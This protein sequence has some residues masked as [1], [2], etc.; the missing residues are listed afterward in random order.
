MKKSTVFSKVLAVVLTISMATAIVGCG[1]KQVYPIEDL[2][3]EFMAGTENGDIKIIDTSESSNMNPDFDNANEILSKYSFNIYYDN[4]SGCFM[5]YSSMDANNEMKSVFQKTMR[6]FRSTVECGKTYKSFITQ[7]DEKA[8]RLVWKPMPGSGNIFEDYVNETTYTPNWPAYDYAADKSPLIMW[9]DEIEAND[10]KGEEANNVINVYMSDLNE[11]N[12]AL[13]KAGSRVRNIITSSGVNNDFL[14]VSYVL[15][16]TGSISGYSIDKDGNSED[17]DVTYTVKDMQD[18][19][20]YALAFG[21]HDALEMFDHKLKEGLSSLESTFN[22]SLNL[23]SYLYRN[24]FYSIDETKTLD[25]NDQPITDPGIVNNTLADY[26]LYNEEGNAVDSSVKDVPGKGGAGK[27]QPK[28]DEKKEAPAEEPPAEKPAGD[29]LFSDLSNNDEPELIYVDDDLFGDA[30]GEQGGEADNESPQGDD[31][32]SGNTSQ[33]NGLK[34][35]KELPFEYLNEYVIPKPVGTSYCYEYVVPASGNEWKLS[36][37]IKNS[38]FYEFDTDKAAA[39]VY[40]PGS[41]GGDL[42]G[43]G[44]SQTGWESGSAVSDKNINVEFTNDTIVVGSDEKLDETHPV[45]A[46]S[47][48]VVYKYKYV[49]NHYEIKKVDQDFVDWVDRC[50]VP[51]KTEKG[52]EYEKL[53]HTLFFDEFIDKIANGYR[54]ISESGQKKL[55][56]TDDPEEYSIAVKKV[57]IIVVADPKSG[58]FK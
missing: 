33:A 28:P 22:R 24:V 16:Y 7:G 5:S 39:Y 43:D 51:D 30:G 52:K 44:D 35:L 29:D 11:N 18:R 34:N 8:K 23:Q 14:I 56:G 13:A 48:P 10:A 49:T 50:K 12:G 54:D 1:D 17:R 37:G 26:V 21:P 40:V 53:T 32:F 31:I 20:Y 27:Q 42:M 45:V 9:L 36:V 57:N 55:V 25:K 6:S 15:P 2:P 46:V 38:D 58:G 19:Y 41:G 3:Q 4:S 47:V